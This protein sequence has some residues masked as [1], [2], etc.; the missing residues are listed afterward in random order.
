MELREWQ[1]K[2]CDSL[3]LNCSEEYTKEIARNFLQRMHSI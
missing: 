2:I 1:H 3:E